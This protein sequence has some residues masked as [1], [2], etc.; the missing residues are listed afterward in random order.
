MKRKGITYFIMS[1]VVV[2]VC[3]GV[4]FSEAKSVT[5]KFSSPF[6]TKDARTQTYQYWADLVNKETNGRVNVIVYP[7]G[8]LVPLQEHY[9]AVSRGSIGGGLF[10]SSYLD[11]MIPEFVITS[12]AGSIPIQEPKDLIKVNKAIAP[13]MTKILEKHNIRYL[14]ATDESTFCVIIRKGLKPVIKLEDFRGLKIRDPGKYTSMWLK[15][16]EASTVT[17]GIGQVVTALQHGTID[18]V[19]FNWVIATAIKAADVAPS[20]TLLRFYGPWV[21]AGINLDIFKSLSSQDQNILIKAGEKS[22]EYS[23]KLGKKTTDEFFAN[24]GGFKL[25]YLD[26]KDQQELMQ[27]IND[28]KKEILK[29]APPSGKELAEA[30]EK[31]AK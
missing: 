7:G 13:I 12:L 29:E 16:F 10:V 24:P 19:V 27:T 5:I 9:H 4:S 14:L 11:P 1:L 3:S 21:F 26:K 22:T 17:L 2:F 18:G 28:V 30:L 15:K 31:L 6:S 23:A 8:S 20:M 25:Y